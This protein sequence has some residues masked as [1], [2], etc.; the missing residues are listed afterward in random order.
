MKKLNFLALWL[1]LVL[2]F[3]TNASIGQTTRTLVAFSGTYSNSTS[4]H[5]NDIVNYNN[6]TYISVVANN[7]G[8]LPTDGVH[9]V[10]FGVQGPTPVYS[11][12]W[13]SGT[14]YSL[15]NFVSYSDGSSYI[16]LVNGNIGNI[17]PSSGS[18]WSLLAAH[19]VAGQTTYAQLYGAANQSASQVL[20]QL[21]ATSQNIFNP[22]IYTIGLQQSNGTVNTAYTNY[23]TTGCMITNGQNLWTVHSLA[24]LGAGASIVSFYADGTVENAYTASAIA[25]GGQVPSDSNAYCTKVIIETDGVPSTLAGY[26]FN[27]GSAALSSAVPYVVTLPQTTL[28]LTTGVNAANAVWTSTNDRLAHHLTPN[29]LDP[30]GIT[31]G[32]YLT[33]NGTLAANSAFT[34]TDF[35]PVAGAANIVSNFPTGFSYGGAQYSIQFYGGTKASPGSPIG[36]TPGFAY[37]ACAAIPVYS[38][39][40]LARV[41]Y[42]P[43]GNSS[44]MPNVTP[45][46]GVG[47]SCPTVTPAYSYTSTIFPLAGLR[48]LVVADSIMAA[49]SGNIGQY[50]FR[51]ANFMDFASQGYVKNFGAD[52]N[53]L[54]CNRRGA[55]S[56]GTTYNDGDLVYEGN[57]YYNALNTST[58]VDPA[59]DSGSSG[60]GVHWNNFAAVSEQLAS[61]GIAAGGLLGVFDQN[62]T[63]YPS[64]PTLLQQLTTLVSG[65]AFILV[66]T[67]GNNPNSTIGNFTDT[68]TNNVSTGSLYGQLNYLFGNLE[69][70]VAATGQNIPIL[71]LGMAQQSRPGYFTTNTFQQVQNAGI[72]WAQNFGIPFINPAAYGPIN[73]YNLTTTLNL[74]SDGVTRVHPNALGAQ[75]Y[76]YWLG[77]QVRILMPF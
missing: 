20:S 64:G 31:V 72:A 46:I 51:V 41:S 56:S 38:G 75:L 62:V 17:P 76:G 58:G 34:T 61:P 70:A 59:T 57:V 30:D 42:L 21:G 27:L 50:A 29:L 68:A 73:Q 44:V 66:E 43:P 3:M 55:Y 1:V 49:S 5:I 16:S 26:T 9:W 77:R 4:Y 67:L 8:N 6:G 69:A 18:Q 28:A 11:G 10:Q 48:T 47:T 53:N 36:Y 52:P 14:T 23:S 33:Q 22:A 71:F 74:E 12:I 25:A 2:A 19:G 37:A 7:I 32:Y 60:Y 40:T 35:F 65:R 54:C 39:A 24:A 45:F 13:S 15:G 63:A